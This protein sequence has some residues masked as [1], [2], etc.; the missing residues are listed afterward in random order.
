MIKSCYKLCHPRDFGIRF[1]TGYPA[2]DEWN[3]Y[4]IYRTTL[5]IAAVSRQSNSAVGKLCGFGPL[6]DLQVWGLDRVARADFG[7]DTR[8]ESRCRL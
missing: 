4:N 1:H 3:I 8:V 6:A 7:E 5:I 2:L